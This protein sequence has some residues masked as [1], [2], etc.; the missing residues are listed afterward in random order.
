[1]YS[2]I[3]GIEHLMTGVQIR[4]E[5]VVQIEPHG[6][7][8]FKL[9][10][11]QDFDAYALVPM[12]MLQTSETDNKWPSKVPSATFGEFEYHSVHTSAL[13]VDAAYK[14]F[15]A[16]GKNR[17]IE[18]TEPP[19]TPAVVAAMR[20]K[21]GADADTYLAKLQWAGKY[22]FYTHNNMYVGVEPDGH[23]HT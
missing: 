23:I 22:W 16:Q 9:S 1:M 8:Q 21:H 10:S 2:T 14:S 20:R 13:L 15:A 11:D 4:A 19:F 12:Q 5:G 18:H 6:S 3:V 7:T 17:T